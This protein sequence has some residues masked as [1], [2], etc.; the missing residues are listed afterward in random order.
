MRILKLLKHNPVIQSTIA[1][2]VSVLTE[3]SIKEIYDDF[4]DKLAYRI[5]FYM[6]QN[7]KNNRKMIGEN[8]GTELFRRSISDPESPE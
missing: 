3:Q 7:K 1:S 4:M 5:A 2:T 8:N 6:H